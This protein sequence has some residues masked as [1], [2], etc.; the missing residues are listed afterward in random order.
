MA[1]LGTGLPGRR[2]FSIHHPALPEDQTRDKE[3]AILLNGH[4]EFDLKQSIMVTAKFNRVQRQNP[5]MK[6][7]TVEWTTIAEKAVSQ[8]R[9]T[10]IP[11]HLL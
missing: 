7:Y 6:D 4:L 2:N 9:K 1:T 8:L 5:G 11:Y 3:L 10:L